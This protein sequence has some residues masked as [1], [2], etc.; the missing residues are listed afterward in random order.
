MGKPP[1]VCKLAVCMQLTMQLLNKQ[2]KKLQIAI[3]EQA[4]AKKQQA[5]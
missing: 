1:T 5:L 3:I 4:L 2:A